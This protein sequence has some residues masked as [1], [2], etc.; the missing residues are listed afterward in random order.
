V[1]VRD[2]NLAFEMFKKGDLDRYVVQRSPRQWVQELNFD[3]VQRGL[4]QKRKVFNNSPQ[5]RREFVFN[6][7]RPPFDDIRV[8]KAMTLLLDRKLI[9]EKIM[10]NEYEPTNSFFAGTPY[11]NPTNP[12]NEYDPQEA[13][14]LLA[15]AGWKSRDSQG[16]LVKN[17]VPLQIELIYR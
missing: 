6:M 16:R 9:V 12:K 11:E 15:D 4:I 13:L 8:R 10:F 1:V 14:K 2:D 3:N 17:G 7:R 5:E